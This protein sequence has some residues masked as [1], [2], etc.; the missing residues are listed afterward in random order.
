MLE[1]YGAPG[2]CPASPS[3][4]LQ[5]TFPVPPALLPA[6]AELTGSL[7]SLQGRLLQHRLH[8]QSGARREHQVLAGFIRGLVLPGGCQRGREPLS[9]VRRQP[10]HPG[11]EVRGPQPVP[12]M[13]ASGSDRRAAAPL[14]RGAATAFLK[15]NRWCLVPAPASCRYTEGRKI[16]CRSKPSQRYLKP[17]CIF[18]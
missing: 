3:H 7:L 11:L 15:E 1:P 18:I 14:A 12:G 5:D 6:L 17:A 10:Q 9:A 13:A 2:L 16:S 8:A 4:V